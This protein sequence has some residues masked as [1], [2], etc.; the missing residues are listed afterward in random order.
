MSVRQPET[1]APT[2]EWGEVLER[3]SKLLEA[4][5]PECGAVGID[6]WISEGATDAR[7][8]CTACEDV[9]DEATLAGLEEVER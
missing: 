9:L 1:S 8:V 7:G 6:V 2:N 4:E 5:C 3:Y